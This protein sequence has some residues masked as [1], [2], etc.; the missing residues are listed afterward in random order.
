M[1]VKIADLKNNLSRYLARVRDTGETIIVCDRDEPVAT[2]SPIHRDD[3]A[4]WQRYR[5]ECLARAKQIGLKIEVPL[6]R[7]T[8]KCMPNVTPRTAPDRRTD[9][10]TIDL[11]RKG[12]NY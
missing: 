8:R 11:T 6:Q 10:R 1:N 9:I 3:D 4:E 2:L 12:R 5:E 7:P